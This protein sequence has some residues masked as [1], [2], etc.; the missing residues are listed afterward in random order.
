M[1]S[2]CIEEKRNKGIDEKYFK[3]LNKILL[4]LLLLWTAGVTALP[5]ILRNG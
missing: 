3:K 4:L 5:Q 2:L 1:H